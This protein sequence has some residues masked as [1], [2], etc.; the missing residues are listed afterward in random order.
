MKRLLR[1]E[2]FCN[3]LLQATS[4]QKKTLIAL[5]VEFEPICLYMPILL[6]N[7]NS[8][9]NIFSEFSPMCACRNVS[10]FWWYNR[11]R[12]WRPR[13]RQFPRERAR[14][15]KK[16]I[17]RGCSG[18]KNSTW[19]FPTTIASLA[20]LRVEQSGTSQEGEEWERQLFL[21]MMMV[22]VVIFGWLI[23]SLCANVAA[24][25][26]PLRWTWGVLV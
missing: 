14:G 19:E 10:S 17:Q 6:Q 1:I 5:I 25:F 8:K 4:R 13:K 16:K 9:W 23:S 11:E 26:L 12:R 21:M 22:V 15:E 2:D 3:H 18:V 24:L 20:L 7:S